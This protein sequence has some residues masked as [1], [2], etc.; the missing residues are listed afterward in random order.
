MCWEAI[1][2]SGCACLFQAVFQPFL[3]RLDLVLEH[4][5]LILD[6]SDNTTNT[7]QISE[8]RINRQNSAGIKRQANA[9]STQSRVWRYTPQRS[10]MKHKVSNKASP[11]QRMTPYFL[12]DFGLDD[13]LQRILVTQLQQNTVNSK[14]KANYQ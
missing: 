14:R 1:K 10:S 9:R 13:A 11:N 4:L 8:D 12:R 2:V 5:L 7:M 6:L 3:L